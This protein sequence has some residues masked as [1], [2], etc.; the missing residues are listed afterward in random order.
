MRNTS[1]EDNDI[2][3]LTPNEIYVLSSKKHKQTKS[4]PVFQ[5]HQVKVPW[6]L[7]DDGILP[8]Q[9]EQPFLREQFVKLDHTLKKRHTPDVASWKQNQKRTGTHLVP[10]PPR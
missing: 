5:H 1:C 10:A 6:K 7:N 9:N 8:V 3:K 2:E 4:T